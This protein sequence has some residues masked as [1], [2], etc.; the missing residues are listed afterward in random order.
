MIIGETF[1]KLFLFKNTKNME[2][3]LPQKYCLKEQLLSRT[4]VKNCF[5][6]QFHKVAINFNVKRELDHNYS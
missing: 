1:V 4:P 2:Q 3:L 5:F 6:F